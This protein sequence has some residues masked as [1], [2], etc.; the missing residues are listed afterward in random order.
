M[1]S[2]NIKILQNLDRLQRIVDEKGIPTQFF[3]RWLQN[4]G[5]ALTDLD[6]II[7]LLKE[8]V[9]T[10]QQDVTDLEDVE[11]VA[12]DY[13]SGGGFLGGGLP[14]TLDHIM[15]GVTPGTYGTS[16]KVAQIEVDEFGHVVDVAEVNIA[17]GGGGGGWTKVLDW[18]FAVHGA[19]TSIVSDDLTGYNELMV[20]F[21]GVTTSASTWRTVDMSPDGGTTWLA[22]AGWGSAV[23]AGTTNPPYTGGDVRWYVHSTSSA[24]ARTCN[25]LMWGLATNA[26]KP[27]R[28]ARDN[29]GMYYQTQPLNRARARTDNLTA[30]FTGGSIE[31]WAK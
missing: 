31:F 23:S 1:A 8:D 17:G 21:T 6:A 26:P 3:I 11:I 7:T 22:D 16:T 27:F 10:L 28:S 12:G 19:V 18:S 25:G 5:G 4:R 29:L 9:L 2:E 15:S 30:T 14:I 24:A 13:L 20:C